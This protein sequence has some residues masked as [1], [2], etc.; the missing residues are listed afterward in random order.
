[1]P[2]RRLLVAFIFGLLIVDAAGLDGLIVSERCTSLVD[3]VPDNACPATCLRCAC[4]QPM[5]AVAV[6]LGTTTVIQ[7]P[8]VDDSPLAVLHRPASDVFHVPK[9]TSL[10]L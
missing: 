7:L 1:M 5:V 2:V 10:S 8:V 3:T 9:S 4:G 6:N